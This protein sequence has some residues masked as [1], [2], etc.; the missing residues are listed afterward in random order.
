MK[1]VLIV[2]GAAVAGGALILQTV[3]NDLGAVWRDLEDHHP[4]WE[5]P[6]VS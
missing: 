3:V 6:R 1:T 4:S 2:V 5:P